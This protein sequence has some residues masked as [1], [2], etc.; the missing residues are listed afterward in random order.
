[1]E[2]AAPPATNRGVHWT[3]GGIDWL[4]AT[5]WNIGAE[6]LCSALPSVPA[7]ARVSG[8]NGY[9]E[10]YLGPGGIR[11]LF[12]PER[13][14]VHLVVPG[15]WLNASGTVGQ[16]TVL[17]YLSSV[18]ASFTRVDLQLTDEKAVATPRR[19]WDAMECGEGVTRVRKWSWMEAG[20]ESTGSSVYVGSTKSQQRLLVYDKEAESHGEVRGVRWE[21][22]ARD[23][24]AESL[25]AQLLDAEDWGSIWAGRLLGFIDFRAVTET[26]NSGRRPRLDWFEELV[27]GAVKMRGYPA[28]PLRTL[29]DVRKWLLQQVAPSL[30]VVV[31]AA[32]GDL[33]PL[34]ELASHGQTRI[35]GTHR[36][37]LAAAASDAG[38]ADDLAD[39][40][41]SA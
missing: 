20:G 26:A 31:M 3:V 9:T 4:S 39:S 15:A 5:V 16:R 41:E 8:L 25:A 34:I 1:M 28:R 2:P 19:V 32:G 12:T 23:E 35:R 21:F 27:A 24:A 10:S 13:T 33:T 17:E 38:V 18:S 6:D 30:A 37:I 40:P 14:D 36:A 7:W 11:I 29:D 22:R